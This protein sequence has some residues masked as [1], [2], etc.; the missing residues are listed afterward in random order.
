MTELV[1]PGATGASLAPEPLLDVRDLRVSSGGGGRNRPGRPGQ[2]A[3]IVSSISLTLQPGETIGIVGESG[4][5]KSMTAK[6]VTGLLPPGITASGEVR[7][8]G[9]NLLALSEREW[10]AVRGR[11]I[12]L[13]LQDPFTMLNPVLRCGTII[14]ESL[15]RAA[16]GGHRR[17]GRRSE[18]VR[19]LAEVGIADPTVADRYPFQLSGGMRQRVAI[20][21]ALA[22]DPRVLIADEPSTALDA[23]TQQDILALIK[24]VQRA[25][26]MGLVLITHDLRVAFAMCDRIYVL[27]AGSL[28]ETAPAGELEAE[29]LHPYSHGLL[30]SEPPA[31]HRV[32]DLVSIPGSVPA[33]DQVAGTCPFAPR[34]RWATAACE[35]AAPPLVEVALTEAALT[36]PALAGIPRGRLSACVRLPEIRAEMTALRIRAGQRA[37][38][39]PGRSGTPLIQVSELRKVFHQGSR[40]VTALDGVS[41]EVSDGESVGLVGESGSGKTT[42][43]RVLAGLEPATSGQVTIDGIPAADWRSLAGR[44]RRRLRGTVQIVFQDPYS[45]LNPMHTVGAA[46]AEAVTIHDPAARNVRGQVGDLLQ[47]VGLPAGYAQRRPVALSGGERQRVAIARALAVRPRVLICDEPVSALDVSVQAQILNL[48]SA[49]RAERGIGYL[50][51]THDLSIVRQI[52]DYL[53][54]MHHGRVVESGPTDQVLA[55]PSDAYTIKLLDSVPRAEA[56]WLAGHGALSTG[57]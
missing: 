45:S 46:L 21:A 2:L 20:A 41:V 25:R 49:I 23:S 3:T 39:P 32:R 44:D 14:A 43:A 12:G 56:G 31:D 26:G 16:G 37:A 29:P 50:F 36:G 5:G 11:E 4:S 24:R 47:S 52:T 17:D 1:P 35:R 13:I 30:L 8:S 10:R 9:R 6:A 27:Y 15:P 53:Y 48:L 34:C 22:R 28:L 38:A 18:A 19:R 57:N 54:V 51:I 33:P 40:T 7:Y 42:L 55:S